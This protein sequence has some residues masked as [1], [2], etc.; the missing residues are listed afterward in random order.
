MKMIRFVLPG[1]L[2]LFL[3]SAARMAGPSK[4]GEF[5]ALGTTE[6]P[7]LETGSERPMPEAWIDKDTR[8]KVIRLT[9]MGGNN[10]SF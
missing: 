6:L 8:H 9:R 1:M 7:V 2:L 3:G 10:A 5:P 4:G